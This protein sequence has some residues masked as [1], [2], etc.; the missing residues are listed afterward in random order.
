MLTTSELGKEESSKSNKASLLKGN[1]DS[2]QDESWYSQVVP[3]MV[4]AKLLE[5]YFLCGSPNGPHHACHEVSRSFRLL[6]KSDLKYDVSNKFTISE[7]NGKSVQPK[8]GNVLL[9]GTFGWPK[10]SNTHGHGVVVIP[11]Y[12]KI[13][14]IYANFNRFGRERMTDKVFVNLRRYSTGSATNVPEKFTS[15]IERCEKIPQDTMDRK[16]YN[17]LF[18]PDMY[19]L[20]YHK[21]K[22]KPGNMTPGV[23]PETLDG[24]SSE[25]IDQIIQSMKDESFQFKP[26]RRVNIPKANGGTRPLS[27]APPRDK[28]VQ[29]IMRIILDAVFTPTFS[30]NSHGFITNRSCHTAL[31]QIY[32]QFKGVTWVIEGEIYKCFDSIDHHKLMKLIEA[33]IL[34]RKFTKLIWKALRIG[35]FEFHE[36]QHSLI[37]T[38]QGS[39]ISPILCNI[40][41]TQLDQFVE[42]LMLNFN[43]GENPKLNNEYMAR[44]NALARAK[45]KGDFK[46]IEEQIKLMRN[47][48]SVDYY[49]PY[50]RRLYYVRYVD[51]WIVGIRGSHEECEDVLKQINDKLNEIGLKLNMDKTHIT[52]MNK[53]KVLFLGTYIF[54]S[55][56]RRFTRINIGSKRRLG[57]G[58][59]IEVPLDRV[60]K[61][62]TLAGFI[63]YGIPWP[64]FL[65]MYQNKDQILHL[66]N[67]V[68]RGILNYYSFSHNISQLNSLISYI[69]KSSCAKLLV[70]KFSISTQAGVFKRFG[71][72]LEK[73]GKVKFYKANIQ[74]NPQNFKIKLKQPDLIQGLFAASKS[75]ANLYELACAKCGSTYRVEMHHVKMMKDLGTI[76]WADRQ[77]A[78]VNRKQIP[79]CRKCHME[80]HNN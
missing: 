63:K 44:A 58:I 18:D 48:D 4:K 77:M 43:K 17:L 26:S 29:E 37:G 40:F 1:T 64:K 33:K 13:N 56:H 60:T 14:D 70:A 71:N 46:K 45:R 57:F 10:G 39:I 8:D 54:R 15:L 52:N 65:W 9:I 32:M 59:R 21:L 2:R 5:V 62:L 61:K 53:N 24:L 3:S 12:L 49:D 74:V 19:L 79:L 25:W 34:D 72:Q 47:M 50:F 6:T 16:V 75:L 69:I 67:S 38:P 7:I 31:K 27:V 35:Y 42:S 22:S 41:I 55:H 30:K 68:L 73:E 28:V 20:A 78:K 11:E 80:H 66:Y 76:K 23:S 51:D 36:Y